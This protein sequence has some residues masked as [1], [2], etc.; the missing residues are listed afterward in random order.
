MF[1]K[2][3]GA[4]PH[5]MELCRVACVPWV[6][7]FA[8]A[9]PKVSAMSDPHLTERYS[10]VARVFHWLIVA[11]IIVQFAIAW[12][13]PEIERNT[14][15]EGM[16]GWHLTIGLLILLTALARL[17]WRASHKPP[18]PPRGLAPALKLLSRATHI[19]LYALLIVLP[20]MGW[21][22][23]SARGWAVKLFGF[24]PL[25]A[26][27]PSGSAIGR[28]MGDIHAT[29]AIVLLVVIGLHVAG[30]AYHALVLRDRTL[31]RMI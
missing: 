22:N 1:G 3:T 24:V 13:M 11:L 28:Q 27:V 16:V 10:S 20:L 18:P 4:R 31:Q 9:Q 21:I 5:R 26:L 19:G 23:A 14:R 7:P 2:S 12:T 17:F 30:A 8:R 25:P 15:P 6:T 29:T